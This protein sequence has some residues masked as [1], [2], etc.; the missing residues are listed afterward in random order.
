M[1]QPAVCL[2]AL[3]LSGSASYARPRVALDPTEALRIYNHSVWQVED[4]LPQNSI[5]AITQTSDGYLWIGTE[6]GLARFD[7]IQFTVFDSKNTAQLL[8][9]Y[10]KTLLPGRDGSLWIG[11]RRGLTRL[12]DGK[13][14]TYTTREG[15]SGDAVVSLAEDRDG[16]L[17]IATENGLDQFVGGKLHRYSGGWDSSKIS[18]LLYDRD[19]YLWIGTEDQGVYRLKDGR[20]TLFTTRGGLLTNKVLS[21]FQTTKEACGSAPIRA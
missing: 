2:I 13:F 12:K 18:C 3:A 20:S 7:G 14:T 9:G 6:L 8:S 1:K 19:G 5:Q 10:I 21:L 17:W 16:L 4:G 15:L 11:T